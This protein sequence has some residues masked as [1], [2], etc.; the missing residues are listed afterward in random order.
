MRHGAWLGKRS[1]WESAPPR[2]DFADSC[3]IEAAVPHC[4]QWGMMRRLVLFGAVLLSG[5]N[6]AAAPK[7]SSPGV[8]TA[9]LFDFSTPV[10]KPFW[11]A[12]KSEL[13]LNAAS[14]WPER[15][16]DWMKRQ[17]LQ[18]GMEFP[19][20][21]QVR[22]LGHCKADR[23]A[24]W[25]FADG[26]LGWVYRIDGEIQPVAYV[27]CDRI[28]Q[29]LAREL[30]GKNPKERQ[31]EFARAISRVVAHEL[32]HIFLQSAKHSRRGLERARLTPS[33]LIRGGML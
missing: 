16:L 3:R 13:D 31:Q 10:P 33:E 28:G 32:T 8:N 22:L 24:G 11:E 23:T 18:E 5:V 29:A 27:N 25:Q 2:K 15:S 9:V 6:L 30:R 7:S 14:I 20:V 21:I 17:E 26:P 19:E 4:P 1:E 12:L